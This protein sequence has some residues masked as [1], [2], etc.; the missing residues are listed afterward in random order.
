M[1]KRYRLR[2]RKEFNYTY[3]RGKSLANPCLVL[4]YRRNGLN[5]TRVGFSVSKK[6]GKAVARNKIK[7]RLKEIYREDMDRIK[8][9]YDFIFV[10]RI[11][12]RDADFWRLKNQ[13][14]N[15]LRRAAMYKDSGK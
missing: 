6:Y 1:D 14:A 7:R 12:A 8:K 3:K 15:L 11:G 13:M 10:V 5:I 2:K 9:G 4:V